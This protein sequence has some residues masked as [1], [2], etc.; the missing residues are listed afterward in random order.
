[1]DQAA[2]ID[3]MLREAETMLDDLPLIEEDG[4]ESLVNGPW[5]WWPFQW[6]RLI[7]TTL[8]KLV[9]QQDQMSSDQRQRFDAVLR[10]L[11][12]AVPLL[13]RLRIPLPRIPLAAAFE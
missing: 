9:E 1:M 5:L 11:R 4:P 12:E 6:D 8:P 13:E 10:R 7:I 2:R 3:E